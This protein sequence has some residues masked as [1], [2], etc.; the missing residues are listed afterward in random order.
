MRTNVAL[1]PILSKRQELVARA[2][3]VGVRSQNEIAR[4]LGVNPGHYSRATRGQHKT[5]QEMLQ[6]TEE[7]VL[8]LEK[9]PRPKKRSAGRNGVAA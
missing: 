3:A 7:L 6:R 8:E 5:W 9:K 1:D 4:R 2:R